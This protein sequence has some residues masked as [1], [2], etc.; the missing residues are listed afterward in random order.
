M[1]AGF[2][3]GVVDG[4]ALSDAELLA[5]EVDPGDLFGNG[6]LDLEARIDLEEGDRAVFRDEE[7]AGTRADV[8]DLRED[9]LRRRVELGVLVIGEEGGGRLFDELL[10]PTLQ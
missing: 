6:V 10:V 9:R 5:H 7:L 4:A 2:G 8:P 1:T 3:V